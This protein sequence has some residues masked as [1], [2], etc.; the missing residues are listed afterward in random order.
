MIQGIFSCFGMRFV[1]FLGFRWPVFWVSVAVYDFWVSVAVLLPTVHWKIV[2]W[3]LVVFL[4]GFGECTP[5]YS[6]SNDCSPF[7]TNCPLW[8]ILWLFCVSAGCFVLLLCIAELFFAFT[9]HRLVCDWYSVVVYWFNLLDCGWVVGLLLL[10]LFS[11]CGFG[12]LD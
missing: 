7:C 10:L 12:T 11:C 1:W 9:V 2:F 3:V 6:A 5:P 4:L 8:S